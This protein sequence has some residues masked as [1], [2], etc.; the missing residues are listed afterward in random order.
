MLIAHSLMWVIPFHLIFIFP[1]IWECL[2]GLI[3]KGGLLHFDIM[4]SY[5]TIIIDIFEAFLET[6]TWRYLACSWSFESFMHWMYLRRPRLMLIW[7][8]P[9]QTFE[10]LCTLMIGSYESILEILCFHGVI[11]KD[12]ECKDS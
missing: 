10:G 7:E 9:F 2:F 4:I 1:P 5:A 8:P 3:Y 11:L 6:W 12:F